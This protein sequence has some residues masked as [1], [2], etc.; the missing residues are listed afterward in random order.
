MDNFECINIAQAEQLIAEGAVVAD[1]RDP[2]SYQQS[3]INNAIHLSN[4]SLHEFIQSADMD[5]P[6]IICCYH[7]FSSQ[8]AA[9]LLIQQGFDQVYSLDGGFEL[10]QGSRPDQCSSD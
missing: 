1:I 5:V 9:G 2:Q 4:D 6:L 10:W 8:S 7:G 3:H